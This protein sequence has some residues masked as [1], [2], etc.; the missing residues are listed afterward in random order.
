MIHKINIF[1][2]FFILILPITLITGPAI[3][4][5]TITFA[6]IFFLF[7]VFINKYYI[8]IYKNSFVKF[9]IIY[10]LFLLSV[11]L[12]AENIFLAYRDS[13][14]FVRYLALPIFLIFLI[15]HNKKY[16]KIVTGI[17]FISVTFVCI[18]SIYQFLNY[19]PEFGFGEDLLGFTP[20]W[21]GRLTGPFYKEL[22]PGAY[23]SKFGLIG[24]V[25]LID[26]IKNKIR[27]NIVSI[28]Y[29]TLI[30][31]VTFIS[32]ERMAFATFLL[33]LL[34]LIIFYQKKRVLF[35]FSSLLIFFIVFLINKTHPVYNDYKVLE[36]TP[37]HLGLKI[38]KKYL[39]NDNSEVICKKV[40]NLQP[41]FIEIIKNFKDSPYGQIYSLGIQMF[42]E[43]KFQGIGMNNFTYLCQ[44]DDRYKNLIKNY[45]CP[46]HPH[47]IYL[48]W[49]TETGVFGLMFFLAYLFFII[50][51]I[52]VN[53]FNKYSLVSLSTLLIMFWPIMSTGSLLKN[54]NGVSTF[55]IIGL[56]MGLSNI[57]QKNE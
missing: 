26:V 50:K 22:I 36:S 29:L 7:S 23:V 41:R 17:I 4:D 21:Y 18:D 19:D 33:G 47:N 42:N 9:S 38:E 43:H 51:Y 12:F 32:G 45:D 46:S 16:L 49:M 31:V 55:F 13:I 20:N 37:Y 28:T 39:C 25:F 56:C 57:E 30:G 11:S 54:W 53:N 14:I 40:I 44:Y 3:P 52:C 15:F 34:F 10:W 2:T 1:F 6:T 24:L 8:E 35:L 27:Q 48:Q 5:L